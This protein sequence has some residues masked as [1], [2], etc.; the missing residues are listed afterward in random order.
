MLRPPLAVCQ[1]LLRVVLNFVFGVRRKELQRFRPQCWYRL[2]RI[3]QVDGEAVGL[4]VVLH[5]AEHIVIHI[6]EE[7]NFRLNPPI[8]AC[9]CQSRMTVE[10]AGIPAAHLV[11]GDQVAVLYLLLFEHLGRFFEEVIVDPG[12][13]GPMFFRD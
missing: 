3:V 7:M 5:V 11:I 2:R 10:H 6:A 1:P 4:I 8:V 13:Y 9:V 12:W